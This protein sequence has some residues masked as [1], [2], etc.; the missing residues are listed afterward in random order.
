MTNDRLINEVQ[1]PKR[2]EYEDPQ[3]SCDK[4]GVM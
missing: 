1:M 3:T 2:A 4:S